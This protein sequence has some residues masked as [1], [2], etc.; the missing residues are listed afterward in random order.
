MLGLG[1]QPGGNL[2][3]AVELQRRIVRR[4]VL[5]ARA[6]EAEPAKLVEKD[7]MLQCLGL[8]SRAE[9]YSPPLDIVPLADHDVR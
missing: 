9:K 2:K 4:K 7:K 8:E 6:S 5:A 1:V 3:S